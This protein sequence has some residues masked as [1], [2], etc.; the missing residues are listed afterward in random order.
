[1]ETR[2]LTPSERSTLVAALSR[3]MSYV[4]DGLSV[5]SDN[6]DIDKVRAL[7]ADH[8]TVKALI[9]LVTTNPSRIVVVR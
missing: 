2:S 9:H 5:A 3:Q 8:D 7:V 1:M 6:R 4:M